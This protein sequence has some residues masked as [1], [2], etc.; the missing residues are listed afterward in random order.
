VGVSQPARGLWALWF[1]V[2]SL[3]ALAAVPWYI[4]RRVVEVQDEITSVLEPAANLSS[5]L[6]LLKARQMARFQGFL[7]TG[8]R[9]TFRQPYIGG[10]AEE[11]SVFTQLGILARDLDIEIRERLAELSIESTEW[12]LENQRAFDASPE[13]GAAARVQARYQEIQRATRELDR[14]IQ[15]A[16]LAGRRRMDEARMLQ[17]RITLMLAL[18]A[19]GGTLVVGRVGQRLRGL[20]EEAERRRRDA[21]RAR[22]E[23]DSLLEATGDGVLGIDLQGKCI[24]LN[25]AGAQLLGYREREIKGRDVHDTIHH[26]YED[27]TPRLRDSSPI[28]RAL[29]AAEPADSAA[30]DVLWRRKGIAFPARWS[31]R[32]L[33]D[34]TELRGAVL[35][36]TDMTEIRDKEQALRHAIRQRE[37]VVSI[38]SHD[39]RNPLGVV[40]AAADILLELPLDE[41]QRRQQ[42][43][44]IARSATR[45]RNLIDDLLDVSRIE[46]GAL[47]VRPSLE[48]L[49]PIVEEAR[50]IF[51]DQAIA[52]RVDL[53]VEPG[54]GDPRARVDRDRVHQALANLLDNALRVTSEG[55]RV[56][57]SVEGCEEHVLLRVSDTGTG[58]DPHTLEHLF[59]RY[60]QSNNSD[61]GSA[62]LGLA[63]VK[64]IVEAHG[65]DVSVTSQRGAG[66]TFAL[67]LPR[68][69]PPTGEDSGG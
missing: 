40:F 19:L 32:P 4:G 41:A 28:L 35:T 21:V 12:N 3:A 60:W 8:D 43:E 50:D 61:Q 54:D 16:M 68:T 29:A 23:I 14:A 66:T 30:G 33:V 69:G 26:S 27:G 63:I 52:R 13:P 7:L 18:V 34:G 42:I 24:S 20:T 46:A 48:E 65:G 57:L 55:G 62:G 17:A 6:S 39:L 25:R 58:M 51:L 15:S 37:D 31:L 36:F 47:V 64:G 53:V 10:I 22:R 1:I 38:V 44:I 5:R 45:M 67:R 2:A 56:S 11:D 9:T 49:Q 59:D